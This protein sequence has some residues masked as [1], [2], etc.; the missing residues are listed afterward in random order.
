[1]KYLAALKIEPNNYVAVCQV[2][3]LY[4]RIGNRQSDEAK[5]KEDFVNAKMYAA[6]ALKLNANDA[7][8]NYVMAV[9]MGRMALISGTN[10]KVA[11]SRDIK[12]YAVAALG[13]NPNHAGANYVL[14]RWHHEVTN[15]NFFERAAANV[16]FGGIP[17]AS[18]EDALKYLSKA[19][20]LRPDFI[21]YYYDLAVTQNALGKKSEAI[22][23]LKKAIS[24]KAQTEDDPANLTK[25]K[26]LLAELQQ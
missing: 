2:S 5:Q 3:F 4:S 9:A 24:L 23:S 17:E 8:S 10:D 15:L 1:M 12:K 16:L 7:E 6:K 14:G 21:L 13:Y 26:S 22:A 19:V 11:A 25:C 20:S 18:E